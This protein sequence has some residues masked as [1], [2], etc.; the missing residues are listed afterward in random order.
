MSVIKACQKAFC[1]V[2]YEVAL[3]VSPSM[4]ILHSLL[5]I[6]KSGR[7]GNQTIFLFN[8]LS[9]AELFWFKH[10]DISLNYEYSVGNRERR[11]KCCAEKKTIDERE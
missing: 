9:N 8:V 10:L 7:R 2:H 5:D 4:E 6:K 1:K 11:R 3:N